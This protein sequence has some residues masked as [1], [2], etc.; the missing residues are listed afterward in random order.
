MSLFKIFLK[1]P[2]TKIMAVDD[3]YSLNLGLPFIIFFPKK[4][5]FVFDFSYEKTTIEVMAEYLEKEIH[6]KS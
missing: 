2:T 6:S 5:Y 4:F 1:L 3:W